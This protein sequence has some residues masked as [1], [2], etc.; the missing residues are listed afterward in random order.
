MTMF[1]YDDSSSD[2]ERTSTMPVDID[3]MFSSGS[4]S[5]ELGSGTNVPAEETG[6]MGREV[7]LER[8]ND[9]M[10]A[11]IAEL[12]LKL[13]QTKRKQEAL[14]PLG[15]DN[16]DNKKKQVKKSDHNAHLGFG[17]LHAHDEDPKLAKG[18]GGVDLDILD[19]DE[20][21]GGHDMDSLLAEAHDTEVNLDG[22][23]DPDDQHNLTGLLSSLD[24]HIDDE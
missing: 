15:L 8:Q 13:A 21:E 9:E 17:D 22:D 24:E 5:N 10:M 2:E 3:D 20:S 4:D 6:K 18:E 14:P 7:E 16:L 12:E 19:S 23:V 1:N 11:K